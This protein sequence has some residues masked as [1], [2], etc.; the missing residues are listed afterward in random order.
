MKIKTDEDA[1]AL[2]GQQVYTISQN[3]LL[4]MV[5]NKVSLLKTFSGINGVEIHCSVET[6][7]GTFE[8]DDVYKNKDEL[9]A[10]I[11]SVIEN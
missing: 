4:P 6:A 11:D 9:I 7:M 1:Q 2:I 3:K 8:V 10:Y 5:V